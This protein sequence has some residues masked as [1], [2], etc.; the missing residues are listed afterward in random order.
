MLLSG[1][2]VLRCL[3]SA[4]EGAA[5]VAGVGCAPGVLGAARA[6]RDTPVLTSVVVCDERKLSRF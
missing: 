6:R 2:G 5:R 1:R 3:A 4:A